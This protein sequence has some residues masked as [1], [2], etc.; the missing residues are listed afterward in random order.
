VLRKKICELGMG[1]VME[2]AFVREIGADLGPVADYPAVQPDGQGETDRVGRESFTGHTRGAPVERSNRAFARAVSLLT[3]RAR[4]IHIGAQG[5]VDAK[6]DIV[7]AD[8]IAAQTTQILDNIDARLQ[9]AGALPE[10]LVSWSIQIR[11]GA[12]IQAAVAA[13]RQWWAPRP[14]PPVNTIMFV[15]RL[16]RR[17]FLLTIEGVAV[18]PR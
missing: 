14:N 16:P 5:A 8:N 15:P 9:A 1:K 7:G 17:E 11:M 18:V 13:G 4:T 12:D 3:G 2:S 10:D 6:G